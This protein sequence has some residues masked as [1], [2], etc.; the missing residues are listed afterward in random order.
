MLFGVKDIALLEHGCKALE[1]NS[2][3]S[4]MILGIPEDC[5]HEEFEETI[6]VPLKPL[7][8]FEV[9]GK[10][11]L[12]EDR[13]KA[14]IIR[15]AED[16]NYSVVPREI[17]GKG[18]VWRVVYMPRKQDVEFLTKL[19]LFLQSEGRTVEDVARVL[20][21]ELCP[22]ATGPNGLPARQCCA[23][24][25]GEKPGAG[26]TARVDETPPLDSLKK[27]S[28]AGDGKRGKRRPKKN[29]RRH[30]ASDKKL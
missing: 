30:R 23:P 3:K 7:G 2:Y 18:G 22:S 8:K 26:A 24:G 9:A 6:R 25:P 19:N 17:Q 27:E 21:Q 12:E 13:S 4:L 20:R 11:F 14:A 29:R 16:I 28:K 5:N 10:A 1:V 15:L